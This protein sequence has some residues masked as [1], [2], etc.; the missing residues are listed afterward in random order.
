[1]LPLPL[2]DMGTKVWIQKIQGT[3][4][5]RRHLEALGFLPGCEV[6]VLAKNAENL[7]VSVRGSRIAMDS[8]MAGRIL[9]G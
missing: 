5:N 2:T 7:I 8:S 9:V 4:D 1:M 3:D 6:T